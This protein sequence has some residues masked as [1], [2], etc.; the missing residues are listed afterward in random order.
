MQYCIPTPTTDSDTSMGMI[1]VTRNMP[2]AVEECREP[3]G[4]CQIISHCLEGDHS[5]ETASSVHFTVSSDNRASVLQRHWRQLQQ[6]ASTV[7]MLLC[8]E[9]FPT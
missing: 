1:W 2:S 6:L 3:S 8:Q 7:V 5:E 9:P 4:E